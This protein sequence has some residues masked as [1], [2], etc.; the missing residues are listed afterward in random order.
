MSL[1]N[2][3]KRPGSL[4]GTSSLVTVSCAGYQLPKSLPF[5]LGSAWESIGPQPHGR[6]GPGPP[7]PP[8]VPACGNEQRQSLVARRLGS[9]SRSRNR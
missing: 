6:P 4:A 3:S 9:T 5:A 8:S 7:N 1:T 2:R